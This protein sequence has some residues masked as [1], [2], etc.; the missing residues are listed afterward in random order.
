MTSRWIELRFL[1]SVTKLRTN[2]ARA[3][4]LKE[5][6][7]RDRLTLGG[8]ATANLALIGGLVALM[9]DFSP[10]PSASDWLWFT[11]GAT[12]QVAVTINMVVVDLLMRKKTRELGKL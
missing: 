4:E 11:I 8:L 7:A 5:E 12:A 2:M 3:D 10:M 6:L 1:L 9:R